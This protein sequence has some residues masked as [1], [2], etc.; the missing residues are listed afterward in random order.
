MKHT[1]PINDGPC[2]FEFQ[3]KTFTA[4]GAYLDES[5]GGVYV[6]KKDGKLQATDWNGNVI[7]EKVAL[8]SEWTL[9]GKHGPYRMSSIRFKYN[10]KTYAGRYGSDWSQLC[11]V[12]ALK[13]GE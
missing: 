9:H 13:G 12:K 2:D 11:R 3:G 10:G 4:N 1:K 5:G 7:A 8:V 6:V